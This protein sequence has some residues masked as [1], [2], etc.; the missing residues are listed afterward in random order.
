MFDIDGLKHEDSMEETVR[1]AFS[2]C[3]NFPK[4]RPGVDG[5]VQGLETAAKRFK[6]SIP[7]IIAECVEKTQYCP[8]D[9]DLIEVAR[10]LKPAEIQQGPRECP[11]G[12]CDGSGWRDIFHLHTQHAKPGGG[13]W[14]ERETM[15]MA[16]YDLWHGPKPG[17]EVYASRCRCTCHPARADEIEKRG[18]YA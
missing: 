3:P 12:I 9:Y 17:Q 16:Q 14:I 1:R 8:T 15:T 4:D 6:V 5:L 2:R 7:A 10:G 13:C 18:K 11:H